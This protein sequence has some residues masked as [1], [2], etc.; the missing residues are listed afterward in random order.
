[1]KLFAAL[2]LLA[3]APS[4]AADG[5]SIARDSLEGTLGKF[6]RGEATSTDV[7]RDELALTL[8]LGNAGAIS[9]VQYCE[10][11]L[12]QAEAYLLGVREEARVGAANVRAKTNALTLREIV[13]SSCR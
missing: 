4:F 10:A 3:S 11:A 7:S 6:T 12:P 8:A 9:K 1:M 13:R 5:V 2:L